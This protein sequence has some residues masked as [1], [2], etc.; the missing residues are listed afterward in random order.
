MK[1]KNKKTLTLYESIF[2]PIDKHTDNLWSKDVVY[3][4][5]MDNVFLFERVLT[6]VRDSLR[7][8]PHDPQ[9]RRSHP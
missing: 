2:L 9:H 4:V 1:R 6:T 8:P 5:M 3:D 7:T